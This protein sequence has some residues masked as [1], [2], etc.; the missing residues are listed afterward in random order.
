MNKAR[1]AHFIG[2]SIFLALLSL[3]CLG[4]ALPNIGESSS[5]MERRIFGV[6]FAVFGT[7]ASIYF[8]FAEEE[9]P[10]RVIVEAM[11][12]F[13]ALLLVGLSFNV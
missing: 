1:R 9:V 6:A 8:H 4:G 7:S 13:V 5:E 3:F 12:V 10:Q 11:L 2:L